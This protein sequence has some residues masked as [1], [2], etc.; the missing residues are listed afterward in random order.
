VRRT[1][2]GTVGF[3]SPAEVFRI[4]VFAITPRSPIDTIEIV[5][6]KLREVTL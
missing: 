4:F 6:I 2:N 5:V 1:R 3:T